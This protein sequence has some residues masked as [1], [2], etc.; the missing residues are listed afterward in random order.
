MAPTRRLLG[1]L[2]AA[3][4]TVAIAAPVSTASAETAAPV[5]IVAAGWGGSV[6]FPFT[7][8][9]VVWQAPTVLGPAVIG[10][11]II[12]TAPSSFINTNNQVSAGGNV[13]GGQVA[14]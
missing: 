14:P 8:G 1:G 2:V 3:L 6:G 5:P 9:A 11:V 12:T 10:P 7:G 13:A 4:S